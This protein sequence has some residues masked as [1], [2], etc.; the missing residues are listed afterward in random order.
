MVFHIFWGSGLNVPSHAAIVIAVPM[1]ACARTVTAISWEKTAY[2]PVAMRQGI[3]GMHF[4]GVGTL[5]YTY[6]KKDS[7]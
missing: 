6:K 4:L 1:I 3:G 5:G 2:L 7:R